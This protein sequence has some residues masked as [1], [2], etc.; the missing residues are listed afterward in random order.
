MPIVTGFIASNIKGDTTT[1]GRGGSDYTAS[2]LAEGVGASEIEIWTDVDGVMT[3]D[4]KYVE[5]AFTIPTITYQEAIELA[6]TGAKIIYPPTLYPVFRQR[7]LLLVKNTFNPEHSG[8]LVGEKST[9]DVC[10]IKG[11]SSISEATMIIIQGFDVMELSNF[12]TRITKALS[13]KNIMAILATKYSSES[14]ICVAVST[15][16]TDTTKSILNQE[17]KNEITNN[18]INPIVA[19]IGHAVVS[20]IGEKIQVLPELSDKFFTLLSKN[21]INIIATNLGYS[22]LSISVVVK[23]HELHKTLNVVH[24]EF[25]GSLI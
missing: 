18:K 19:M 5:N 7:I 6:H 23:S 25:F 12:T 14:S 9:H 24:E 11:I 16:D 3:A 1:L 17:F 13:Q 22:K 10:L 15:N 21:K 4:P 2:I 20:I 8:T